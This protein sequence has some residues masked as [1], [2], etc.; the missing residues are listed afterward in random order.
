MGPIS[1]HLV[2]ALLERTWTAAVDATLSWDLRPG[3]ILDEEA[4]ERY[5][6]AILGE[7]QGLFLTLADPGND[8]S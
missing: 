6:Q 5:K 4:Y 8:D 3:G 2:R 7:A 1:E